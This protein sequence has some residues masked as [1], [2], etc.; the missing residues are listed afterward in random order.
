MIIII[1]LFF[2]WYYSQTNHF[3]WGGGGGFRN[4]VYYTL[5]KQNS[6]PLVN[7]E[8]KTLFKVQI[9]N[10]MVCHYFTSK[11]TMTSARIQ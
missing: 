5:P 4:Y 9:S 1:K 2:K 7:F 10:L 6:K 11:D 3:F 8:K